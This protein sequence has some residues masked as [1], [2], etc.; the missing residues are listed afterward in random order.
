MY[1]ET[2]DGKSY[3][4]RQNKKNL[5]KREVSIVQHSNSKNG[6]FGHVKRHQPSQHLT[7]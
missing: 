5:T 1:N 4:I 2:S 7:Q 6:I 3:L